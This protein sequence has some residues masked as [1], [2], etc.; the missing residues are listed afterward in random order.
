MLLPALEKL[1]DFPSFGGSILIELG[2]SVAQSS[3]GLTL[4]SMVPT[5]NASLRVYRAAPGS[6]KHALCFRVICVPCGTPGSFSSPQ[7]FSVALS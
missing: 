7:A 2:E 3:A 1:L 5:P 6:A 4:V